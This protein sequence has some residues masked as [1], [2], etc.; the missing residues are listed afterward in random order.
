VRY[1]RAVATTPRGSQTAGDPDANARNAFP[2][3]LGTTEAAF[4][5][6]WLAYLRRL[7]GS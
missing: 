2:A 5:R 6:D 1:Y 4:T 7:A 3:V